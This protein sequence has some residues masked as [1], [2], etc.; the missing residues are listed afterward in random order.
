[1]RV[2]AG[3]ARGRPL[4][5]PKK[6]PTRPTS[7]RVK[8]A[9]F[10]MIESLLAWGRP[11]VEI[12]SA[13]LWR[14]LRVADVYAGSGALGIEAL[15]R[16][17]AGALFLEASADAV[18][19]IRENLRLTGTAALGDV[20]GG[21]VR[22]TLP[23]L[24]GPI[25]LAVMDPPYADRSAV[26]VAGSIAAAAWLADDA[27]LVLE[28]SRRLA[29]PDKLGTLKRQRD[30]RYGD[31]VVTIYARGAYDR[32]AANALAANALKEVDG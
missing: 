8:E 26:E 2:I 23:T 6:A 20:R 28:H 12:G 24:A 21:D 4:R 18:A 1:M 14:G 17:A 27:L 29:A 13:E 30:R 16:G 22:R 10:S 15:S 5:A 25:D 11:E 9:L 31:T 7:D 32:A 19:A 3:S